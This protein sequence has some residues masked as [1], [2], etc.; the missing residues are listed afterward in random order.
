MRVFVFAATAV[1]GLLGPA[2]GAFA[3]DIQKTFEFK[4]FNRIAVAGVYHLDVDVGGDYSVTLSGPANEMSRVDAALKGATLKLDL[5]DRRF[6]ERRDRN[7]GVQARIT[8][9]SLVGLHMSGVVD[10][11][12]RGVNSDNF[13]VAISGVGEMR[14]HGECNR[15]NA[16]VSGVGGLDSEGLKCRNVKVVVSG[17]GEAIVYAI[18]AVDAEVSGMGDITVHG[19]PKQVKKSGGMFAD[20]SIR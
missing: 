13:D 15:L 8:L 18:D 6:G 17:V 3:Q 5:R 14:L 20:I 19:S 16:E 11:E 1:F 9:P 4:D 2:F 12:I 7:D 10:G